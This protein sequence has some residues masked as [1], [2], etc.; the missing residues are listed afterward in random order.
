[1]S[2]HELKSTTYSDW[3]RKGGTEEPVCAVACCSDGLPPS[4]VT[5]GFVVRV[6]G[7]AKIV[8]S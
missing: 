1:V 3:P 2:C 5:I 8:E 7:E 6:E 4:S